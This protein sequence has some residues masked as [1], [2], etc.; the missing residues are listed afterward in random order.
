MRNLP[1]SPSSVST[2]FETSAS[3]VDATLP[4]FQ[5]ESGDVNNIE[6][7]R[8][9]LNDDGRSTDSLLA[10]VAETARVLAGADVAALALRQNGAIVCRA[11]SGPI[12][13]ELGAPLNTEAGISGQCLRTATT[14]VSNDTL[15][16]ERVDPDVC[17]ELGIR[18]IAV[19][20]LHAQSGVVGILEAFAGR[21]GIFESDQL[22]SLHA[23]AD[24]AEKVYEREQHPLPTAVPVATVRAK[25]LNALASHAQQDITLLR[26]L[27]DKR[28]YRIIAAAAVVMVIL[29]AVV[30]TTVRKRPTQVGAHN[31]LRQSLAPVVKHDSISASKGL[32]RPPAPRSNETRNE[33]SAEAVLHKAAEISPAMDPSSV[34]SN[35]GNPEKGIT[36]A[37]RTES[38][39]KKATPDVPPPAVELVA[40]NNPGA[41]LSLITTSP[42]LPPYA[43][44][45]SQVTEARLIR[46]VEPFY[47]AQARLQRLQ[48]SVVLDATIA[49]DGTVRSTKVVSGPPMLAQAAATAVTNWRYA[50]AT[51]NGKPTEVVTRITIVFKLP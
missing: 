9:A 34:Q 5:N 37:R 12:G 22:T 23:L 2:L 8:H 19:V 36:L 7:L 41:P 24:I 6:F 20:P 15:K 3:A 38:A 29:S 16:D 25:L 4:V 44:P 42:A 26:K 49:Q 31:D 30:W 39:T 10:A 13:P 46:R 1:L 14:L 21:P 32:S 40:T 50:A 17:R 28:D 33:P 45:V 11:R 48:G 43:G 27:F 35:A 47:P 51:L 18:S